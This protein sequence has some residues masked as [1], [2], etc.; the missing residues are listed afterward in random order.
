M[1]TATPARQVAHLVDTRSEYRLTGEVVVMTY[2][3]YPLG[4][5]RPELHPQ[6]YTVTCGFCGSE[7]LIRVDSIEGTRMARRR[8]L[9]LGLLGVLFLG[10]S[11]AI[12]FADPL[13][14]SLSVALVTVV[15]AVGSLFAVIVGFLTSRLEDGTRLLRSPGREGHHL[16]YP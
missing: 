8:W 13:H 7:L 16:R 5:R 10:S 11:I 14:R 1:V 15:M 12:F 6:T 4:V 9:M 3:Q 2:R